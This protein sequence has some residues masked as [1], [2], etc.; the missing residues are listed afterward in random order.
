MRVRRDKLDL[1]HTRAYT[2][3]CISRHVVP[4]RRRIFLG[5]SQLD[6]SIMQMLRVSHE[7]ATDFSSCLLTP[8]YLKRA[9][10]WGSDEIVR[11]SHQEVEA[12]DS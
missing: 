11:D 9:P 6:G 12:R 10:F 4:S 8:L 2:S 7:V 1:T 5:K 3:S